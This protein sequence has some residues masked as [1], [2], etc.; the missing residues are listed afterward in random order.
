MM[1]FSVINAIRDDNIF[2]IFFAAIV[3]APPHSAVE[4]LEKFGASKAAPVSAMHQPCH[5][6]APASTLRS[7]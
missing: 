5:S 3:P 7:C 6:L 2:G 1:I 4:L